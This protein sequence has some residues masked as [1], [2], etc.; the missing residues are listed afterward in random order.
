MGEGGGRG[1]VC[2]GE[3]MQENN[4]GEGESEREKEADKRVQTRNLMRQYT[5]AC[6]RYGAAKTHRMPEVAGHFSPKSH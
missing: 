5:C 4:G 1:K 6:M 3:R 2:V